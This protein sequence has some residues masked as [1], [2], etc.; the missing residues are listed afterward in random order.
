MGILKL[1][2]TLSLLS[3]APTGHADFACSSNTTNCEALID[4][5]TPNATTLSK[6]KTFFGVKSLRSIL[7]VN[8]LPVSTSGSHAVSA[9]ETVRIPFSC[10]CTNG[11]GKSNKRPIYT[12]VSGDS[13][14]YIANT[15]FAG[16]VTVADIGAANQIQNVSLIVPGQKLWIPLP[17]SCDKVNGQTV[18]HYGH[19]VASGSSV[20][21]IA[22]EYGSTVQTLLTLNNMSD[23]SKL[24]AG[25]VF[26][27]PLKACSSS[28]NS[29][30][31][32]YP[33]LVGNGT[34]VVTA[35]D[36]VLCNCSSTNNYTLDCQPSELKP[37]SSKWS[38]CPSTLCTG[39]SLNIGNSTS[40]NC[41]TTTCSYAG[42]TNQSILTALEVTTNQTCSASSPG[43]S[44]SNQASKIHLGGWIS[45][46]ILAFIHSFVLYFQHFW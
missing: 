2:L 19:V 23:P 21:Q 1:F 32:D 41:N 43:S 26:D 9:Q 14:Y 35:N 28:V 39:S 20:A 36:C 18:V 22:Q 5:V 40:T 33:L 13:L 34:Y 42:Y 3:I 7:G 46:L 11:T 12:V 44:P 6:L 29:S 38:T 4:Y 24:L 37:S 25:Q 45:A 15:V 17:C 27:V 31:D 8:N 10:I 30:S 16:L